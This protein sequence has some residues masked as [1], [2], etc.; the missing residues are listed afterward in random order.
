MCELHATVLGFRF[1]VSGSKFQF[2][3]SELC[4]AA[5]VC[6]RYSTGASG[7]ETQNSKLFFSG[8]QLALGNQPCRYKFENRTAAVLFAM[9]LRERGRFHDS[10]T[11][12]EFWIPNFKFRVD[13][14]STGAVA[15]AFK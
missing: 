15:T 3:S 5:R 12:A 11:K 8:W 6:T 7:L 9:T 2:R 1:Q 4:S 10:M 13:S 14:V